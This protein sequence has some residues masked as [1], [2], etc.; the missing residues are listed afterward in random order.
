MFFVIQPQTMHT[1]AWSMCQR[2]ECSLNVRQNLLP[3]NRFD[4]SSLTPHPLPLYTALPV[5][6]LLYLSMHKFRL[7]YT[8]SCHTQY[9]HIVVVIII[10]III[11]QWWAQRMF[12]PV[13]IPQHISPL[14]WR[15]N[16]FKRNNCGEGRKIRMCGR[17]STYNEQYDRRREGKAFFVL[18]TLRQQQSG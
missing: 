15:E 16:L 11:C 1:Y 6:H 10:I 7:H 18:L 5:N 4:C 14:K 17:R 13:N 12:L 3:Q 9:T 8:W 2:I